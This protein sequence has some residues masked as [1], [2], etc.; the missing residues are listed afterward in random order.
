[1]PT[2]TN[3]LVVWD[4]MVPVVTIG[5][6]EFSIWDNGVPI[7]DVD[8]SAAPTPPIVTARRRSTIF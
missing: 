4:N 3:E 5:N 2:Q 8:E 6:S 1:M 7:V